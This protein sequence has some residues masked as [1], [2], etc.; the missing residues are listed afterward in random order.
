M[1]RESSVIGVKRKS[2]DC[3]HFIQG[4]VYG[5]LQ[6][7]AKVRRFEMRRLFSVPVSQGGVLHH[8]V[9]HCGG[10]PGG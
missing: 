8:G 10:V 4:H 5:L 1:D 7:L 3:R 6:L 2:E 9:L